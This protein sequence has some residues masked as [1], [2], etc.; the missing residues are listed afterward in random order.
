ML[1]KLLLSL[2]HN[3]SCLGWKGLSSTGQVKKKSLCGKHFWSYVLK[4]DGVEGETICKFTSLLDLKLSCTVLLEQYSSQYLLEIF[5]HLWIIN[6]PSTQNPGTLRIKMS[7]LWLKQ[8]LTGIP[9]QT[10]IWLL[11][12]PSTKGLLY[13][14]LQF[15]FYSYQN[16]CC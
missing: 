10:P 14:V 3:F 1:R 15:S 9:W 12:M 11:L 7:S 5:R 2:C 6:W 16:Y 13:W 4:G 8:I